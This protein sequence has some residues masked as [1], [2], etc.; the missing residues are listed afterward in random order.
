MSLCGVGKEFRAGGSIDELC[1]NAN[2]TSLK[3]LQAIAETVNPNETGA[4]PGSKV[5]AQGNSEG[6][7]QARARRRFWVGRGWRCGCLSAAGGEGLLQVGDDVVAVL[8]TDRQAHHV[9]R[10]PGFFQFLSLI[11][12]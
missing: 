10:Y 3:Y 1:D 5:C 11:H 6:T 7:A 8:D 4:L 12:I 9:P 2:V